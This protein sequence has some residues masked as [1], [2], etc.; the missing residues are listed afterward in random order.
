MLTTNG[1]LSVHNVERPSIKTEQA[2]T[3]T[4]RRN[5]MTALHNDAFVLNTI[6]LINTME[7]GT[8][9]SVRY[10][11]RHAPMFQCGIGPPGPITVFIADATRHLQTI[12]LKTEMLF[13]V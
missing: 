11:R 5:I 4:T 7:E 9:S 8:C 6:Y 1:T 13:Q 10:E 12:V 3:V 2:Y